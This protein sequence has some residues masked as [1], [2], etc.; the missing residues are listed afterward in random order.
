MPSTLPRPGQTDISDTRSPGN[1]FTSVQL[2]L[3]S[4]PADLDEAVEAL[5]ERPQDELQRARKHH[6]RALKAL[7]KGAYEALPDDTRDQLIERFQT[8]LTALNRALKPDQSASDSAS[9]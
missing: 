1:P 9:R 8:S 3:D 5:R 2:P 7:R 6:R 4:P